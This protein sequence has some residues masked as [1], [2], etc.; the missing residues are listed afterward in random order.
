MLFNEK[1]MLELCKKHSIDVVE[2]E[3][4]PLFNGIELS[5]DLSISELL[6]NPHCTTIE[7]KTLYSKSAKI[8]INFNS[9]II[10]E[11]TD[12]TNIEYFNVVKDNKYSLVVSSIDSD[13]ENNWAA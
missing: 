1:E 5:P 8:S 13:S 4:Y 9:N 12:N 2:K 11:N 10:I 6:N 3:G 7:E